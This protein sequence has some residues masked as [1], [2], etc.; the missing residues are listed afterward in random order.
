MG[1]LRRLSKK[2]DQVAEKRSYGATVRSSGV[3]H[4]VRLS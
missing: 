3:Y 4:A 2:E 1:E